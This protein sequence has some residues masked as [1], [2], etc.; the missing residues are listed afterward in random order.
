ML[1]V[2]TGRAAIPIFWKIVNRWPTPRELVDGTSS[3]Y[4]RAMGIWSYLAMNDF[5]VYLRQLMYISSAVGR[6]CGATS[7]SGPLQ[8]TGKVVQ[9]VFTVLHG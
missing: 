4:M 2:T 6:A 3:V 7:P 9:R 8:Q 5:C 1:N